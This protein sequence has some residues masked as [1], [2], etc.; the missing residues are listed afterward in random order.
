ML[1]LCQEDPRVKSYDQI[2][3]FVY[4]RLI[5]DQFSLIKSQINTL[6]YTQSIF[7]IKSDFWYLASLYTDTARFE[8]LGHKNEL[9]FLWDTL[10]VTGG[11]GAVMGVN[12]WF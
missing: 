1:T 3:K 11:Y 9:C 4:F 8:W 5:F 7:E 12:E 6:C 2:L 10:V